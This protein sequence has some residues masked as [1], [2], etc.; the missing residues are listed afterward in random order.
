MYAWETINDKQIR[1]AHVPAHDHVMQNALCTWIINEEMEVD[2]VNVG[3]GVEYRTQMA[4][5]TCICDTRC[6]FIS[7]FCK[8]FEIFYSFSFVL[9]FPECCDGGYLQKVWISMWQN[10]SMKYDVVKR[11]RDGLYSIFFFP[12]FVFEFLRNISRQ[13]DIRML[14]FNFEVAQLLCHS[15]K[16]IR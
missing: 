4:Q 14:M 13:H 9:K 3:V 5:R 2:I 1:L 7:F 12:T 16:R 8:S 11:E 6:N 15:E 10:I